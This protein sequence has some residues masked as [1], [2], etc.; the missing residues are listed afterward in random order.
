[1]ADHRGTTS[2]GEVAA[3]VANASAGLGIL[4][5]TFFPLSF[6]GLLLFVIAPVALA[7]APLVLILLLAAPFVLVFRIARA[8]AS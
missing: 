6:G 3:A 1:M 8:V 4:T 2:T 5:M 7:I